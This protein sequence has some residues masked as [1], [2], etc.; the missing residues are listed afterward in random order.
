MIA[1][2]C[3]GYKSGLAK[4]R[5]TYGEVWEGF[6][7]RVSCPLSMKSRHITLLARWWFSQKLH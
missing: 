3:K 4:L 6:R 2:Y 1:F 7:D 5:D